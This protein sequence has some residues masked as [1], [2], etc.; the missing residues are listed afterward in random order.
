MGEA[1]DHGPGGL[2]GMQQAL[3]PA[4]FQQPVHRLQFHQQPAVLFTSH[5][6]DDQ[7]DMD[8]LAR[9]QGQRH[10]ATCQRV[11]AC[12]HLPQT[13]QP[14][15]GVQHE[16]P[17]MRPQGAR[18]GRFKQRLAGRIQA[19]NPQFRIQPQHT[20]ADVIQDVL[21]HHCPIFERLCAISTYKKQK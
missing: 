9:V 14:L 7:V 12:Q 6:G 16:L 18:A 5:R 2:L 11:L 13:C 19:G 10:A 4:D 20:G 3:L 15:S 21:L 1:A 17:G 8:L